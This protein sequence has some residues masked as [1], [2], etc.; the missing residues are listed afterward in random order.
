MIPDHTAL[1]GQGALILATVLV[2]W[3]ALAL[4]TNTTQA[5]SPPPYPIGVWGPFGVSH[6][7]PPGLVNNLGIV[8]I[9]ISEDWDIV[10][11]APGVYDWSTVDARIAQAKAAGFNYIALA[12]I[13]SSADTPTWVL[14]SLPDNQKID[15]LDVASN[16]KTFCQPIHTALYW[17]PTFH[18]AR[19][20]LIAAA[21]AKY[22]S[23]PA[24]VAVNMAAFANHDSNDWN[25]QDTVGTIAC[26]NCPQPPPTL[27]GNIYV[28]QPAQ[29]IAAGWTEQR[30][31][32]VGK[33]MCDAAAA[34]FPN[35][36]IKLPIGGLSDIRMSS[37]DP[38]HTN[39]TYT[40][41]CRDIEN[42]VYGNASLGIPPRPY[43]NRFYMQR[44]TVDANW[45]DGTQ[46]DT[47]TPGFDS[48]RYIKYM[49]RAHA[50]PN[51][52]WT[53]PGQ[54]GLQMVSAASLG[55]TTNCRQDGG[56]TGPCGATCPPVCVMQA[57]LDVATTYNAAF[58]ELWAQDAD[59]P[60][61]YTM[62]TAA[63]LAMGG[64]PRG[65][66]TPTPTLTP[67]PT[68]TPTPTAT[69]TPTP[70]PT[71]TP[72]PTPTPTPTATPTVTPTPT[73]T[74]T[75]GQITLTARGY[76]V[77]GRQTV[78]LSWSGA[79]SSN[80]DIYRNGVLITTV[81][82]NGFYTDRIGARG[83]GTY[84]YQVCE[85]GTTTCSNQATVT[86]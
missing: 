33:E 29:W 18:Q 42:Y 65:M 25:I 71:V 77:Q 16:H 13:D 14:D 35:Q 53:T 86:F 24:I 66:P 3:C 30:M 40:T 84:T 47:Y 46:Y 83:H 69:P 51:P 4:G 22:T 61:F 74:P 20:D 2:S 85:A 26:P 50:H 7:I 64:T 34:A 57:S 59:N 10:N 48:Q 38:G 44:N 54:A 63:T 17:N 58:I 36:N 8:G 27:C 43:A 67:T 1:S 79:T 11:P 19:L 70:T 81:P 41:L 28:D 32:Q 5:Q 21:G 45:G 76:K 23:D 73:P 55:S 62:I 52:P 39:G 49:I 12:I 78:D 82:N 68:P 60:D 31:L 37:T 56:P 75:P 80:V 15:L 72:T 9:L 6:D